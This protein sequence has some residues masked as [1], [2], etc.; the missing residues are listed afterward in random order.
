[1][2]IVT[3]ILATGTSIAGKAVAIKSEP[4]TRLGKC[5]FLATRP[6]S[7]LLLPS[8]RC[9]RPHVLLGRFS[10]GRAMTSPKTHNRLLVFAAITSL[11][12]VLCFSGQQIPQASLERIKGLLQNSS[13]FSELR[14][15]YRSFPFSA[16]TNAVVL[17]RETYYSARWRPPCF[18]LA[19]W[20]SGSHFVI[21]PQAM[22]GANDKAFWSIEGNTESVAER[23]ALGAPVAWMPPAIGHAY[24]VI[25][26]LFSLGI[27]GPRESVHWTGTDF[28]AT[29]FDNEPIR[30]KIAL[31]KT[32]ETI[33]LLLQFPKQLAAGT[34]KLQF[35]DSDALRGLPER[36]TLSMDQDGLS[37]PF[38]QYRIIRVK[39]ADSSMPEDAFLPEAYAPTN[40]TTLLYTENGIYEER[41]T[42][43][44]RVRPLDR[45]PSLQEKAFRF[46]VLVGLLALP[47]GL[48]L[49]KRK[50]RH[51]A[52]R[53]P[54]T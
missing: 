14:F 48:A 43:T 51:N 19:K 33:L 27:P 50:Q 24:R 23:A 30:G 26:Q 31:G 42:N 2:S 17:P 32:A 39:A 49:V 44:V 7:R 29:S 11:S 36:I 5:R 16:S 28:W 34:C 3:A 54:Q 21:P 6:G 41:G 10:C 9:R 45:V 8:P 35:S 18:T 4:V 20:V 37:V 25:Q 38:V 40:A 1:M 22:Y 47:V 12:T 13:A 52:N 15:S 46:I 53:K